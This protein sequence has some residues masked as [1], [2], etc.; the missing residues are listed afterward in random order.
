[1]YKFRKHRISNNNKN[2]EP[3]TGLKISLII[4]SEHYRRIWKECAKRKTYD[5]IPP[6]IIK[7]QPRGR[8]CL[9]RPV[10]RSKYCVL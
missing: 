7:Y 8:R 5:K 2:E 10:N 6:K 3:M 1:L 4:D 9:G